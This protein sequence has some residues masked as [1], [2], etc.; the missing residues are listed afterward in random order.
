MSISAE[1]VAKWMVQQLEES[2][3]KRLNQ[4]HAVIG[5]RNQFGEQFLRNGGTSIESNVLAH[6]RKLAYATVVWDRRG[7]W[8]KRTSNGPAGLEG[9]INPEVIKPIFSQHRAYIHSTFPALCLR[10]ATAD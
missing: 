9:G 7:F 4:E 1:D 10:I 8:R 2:T 6:F 5:I 3:S